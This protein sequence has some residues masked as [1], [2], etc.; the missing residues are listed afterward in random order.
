VNRVGLDLRSLDG[1]LT[2]VVAVG[3][4]GAGPAGLFAANVLVSAGIECEVLERLDEEAVRARARAGL[5]EDRTARLLDAHGLA[6]G[7]VKRGKTLGS[8]E[9]RRDRRS[10]V[11]AYG[12]LSGGRHYVYPQQ[13]LVGD[14][15]DSL[16]SA[17]G[18]VRFA[19]PVD[20][21]ALDGQPVIRTGDGS[22]LRCDFVLG[23]DG[24]HGVS[25]AAAGGT[26]SPEV[27][28]DAEWLAL[29]A[30]A[31][32][33]SEHQ[34]YG[35]HREGFAGHMHRT[36]T[37]SRFYLQ[38][39]PGTGLR[40][41]DDETIWSALDERLAA[42]DQVVVHGPIIERSVLELRSGVTQPMQLGPLYLA[43]DAAH[44]VTPAGG[45]GMNLALQ[46]VAELVEGLVA[47][48]RSGD[49]RRLDA[50]SSIRLPKVWRAVEFSHS[51]LQMLLAYRPGT[52][53][54]EFHEG[55][56]STRLA[57]L[58][59]GGAFAQDFAVTYV[60]LDAERAP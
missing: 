38:V 17:G 26:L 58:M 18:D 35:L 25:R 32:P 3:I 15:I 31:P 9:F 41:W 47:V 42:H 30:E 60:G 50:Y 51:M 36:A 54:G 46:D 7:M 45:K 33:S 28:F 2:S 19:T 37:T 49:R 44:I 13:F 56:R 40:E 6:D 20:A 22:P 21:I 59:D 39:R 12:A 4:V 43:G 14:L 52:A 48:Y 27:D 1:R 55:L 8:C 16:R 10:Y 57:H 23:C 34:I 5:I 24:F 11:F 29:L 53:A